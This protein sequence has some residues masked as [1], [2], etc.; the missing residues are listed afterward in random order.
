MHGPR[1]AADMAH[2]KEHVPPGKASNCDTAHVGAYDQ[3]AHQQPLVH[4]GVHHPAACRQCYCLPSTVRLY[5]TLKSQQAVSALHSATVQHPGSA[6]GSCQ[7]DHRQLDEGASRAQAL[8]LQGVSWA[9]HTT[10]NKV[11]VT[12]ESKPANKGLPESYRGAHTHF[13][14]AYYDTS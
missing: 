1:V 6:A 5:R 11:R 7:C 10:A 9:C 13:Q 8:R 2:L 4:N 3:V 14:Q 12:F